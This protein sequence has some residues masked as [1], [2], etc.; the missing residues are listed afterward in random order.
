MLRRVIQQSS[1]NLL[2]CALEA[3]LVSSGRSKFR[4]SVFS[5]VI[6]AHGHWVQL[7]LSGPSRSNHLLLRLD[8]QAD[9][10]DVL[11]ALRW[12]LSQPNPYDGSVVAVTARN[13]TRMRSRPIVESHSR[14][15]HPAQRGPQCGLIRSEENSAPMGLGR[16]R[17]GGART[18]AARVFGQR[19]VV[20]QAQFAHD[21][22]AI[23]I[24][25]SGVH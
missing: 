2:F 6:D 19:G 15:V 10:R 3:R 1:S 13:T 11:R 4:V 22:P 9:V 16:N 8:E 20:V 21:V 24:D 12:R 5:V 23:D 18:D 25:Q 14:H 7:E 17:S